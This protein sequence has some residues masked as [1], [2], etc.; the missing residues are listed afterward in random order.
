MGEKEFKAGESHL[1]ER[2]KK[3]DFVEHALQKKGE[4]TKKVEEQARTAEEELQER[5]EAAEK[6][7][8][9]YEL[10]IRSGA[11]NN[12]RFL[13][14]FQAKIPTGSKDW[15]ILAD[16][17][18]FKTRKQEEESHDTVHGHE[19]AAKH[20]K[21]KGELEIA[22]T[23]M[24]GVLRVWDDGKFTFGGAAGLSSKPKEGKVE[25]EFLITGSAKVGKLDFSGFLSGPGDRADKASVMYNLPGDTVAVGGGIDSM[26]GNRPVFEAT[27]SLKKFKLP[28]GRV[29]VTIS[30]TNGS[31]SAGLRFEF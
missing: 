18:F 12:P 24:V 9:E 16:A 13:T 20:E 19:V 30:P 5:V 25:P 10:V 1:A 11:K 2:L 23:G 17:T 14:E 8:T 3:D 4:E 15:K 7:K 28:N 26:H 6:E 31:V 22:A 29:A 27:A 21:G